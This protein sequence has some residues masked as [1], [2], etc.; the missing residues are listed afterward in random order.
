MVND[1]DGGDLAKLAFALDFAR[2]KAD[3]RGI[4][5][6]NSQGSTKTRFVG[7]TRLGFVSPVV[8]GFKATNCARCE[9]DGLIAQGSIRTVFSESTEDFTRCEYVQ[10][11]TLAALTQ[12]RRVCKQDTCCFYSAIALYTFGR[13]HDRKVIQQ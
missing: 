10:F 4:G 3:L 11:F 9:S 13:I 8:L 1:D 12:A 2:C 6:P 7:A 5:E